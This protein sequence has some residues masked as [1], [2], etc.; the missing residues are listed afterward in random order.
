[1][2]FFGSD[3]RC[4]FAFADVSK[5]LLQVAVGGCLR[6]SGSAGIIVLFWPYDH[7]GRH[8]KWHLLYTNAFISGQ[9]SVD[10]YTWVAQ[11]FEVPVFQIFRNVEGIFVC[12]NYLSKSCFLPASMSPAAL[13]LSSPLP[14]DRQ[15]AFGLL[16]ESPCEEIDQTKFT[17]VSRMKHATRFW[18]GQDL[19][20][21]TVCVWHLWAQETLRW[22]KNF[23]GSG[24]RNPTTMGHPWVLCTHVH[25]GSPHAHPN[26]HSVFRVFRQNTSYK[27][28]Y[29]F[30]SKPSSFFPAF[31]VF[32]Y[33][34]WTYIN[35]SWECPI[36]ST[37]PLRLAFNF[38]EISLTKRPVSYSY[39]ARTTHR[40]T[41]A[42]MANVPGHGIKSYWCNKTFPP[43]HRFAPVFPPIFQSL[44][45]CGGCGLLWMLFQSIPKCSILFLRSLD[46]Q[47]FGHT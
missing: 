6:R 19:E 34:Q 36:E 1:M 27:S 12:P 11:D 10:K 46:P 8:Q 21:V 30:P 20:Y 35:C 15:C 40:K 9:M 38:R 2:L 5:N 29:F 42:I 41:Q 26:R 14:R 33:H 16:E 39:S 37:D 32:P 4:L 22:F 43:F 13:V 24:Q 18:R 25:P 31:P 45:P 7:C 44:M 23:H 28:F 17:Y 47:H 3:R